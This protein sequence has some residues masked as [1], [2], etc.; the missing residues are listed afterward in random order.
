MARPNSWMPLYWADYWRKTKGLTAAQHGAY[1]N[2]IGAYWAEGGL[3]NDDGFLQRAS[4]MT[5]KE[6]KANKAVIMRYFTVDGDRLINERADQEI[7]SAT[8]VYEKR[9]LAA[10]KTNAHRSGDRHGDRGADRIDKGTADRPTTHNSHSTTVETNIRSMGPD[11]VRALRDDFESFWQAYPRRAGSNPKKTATIAYLKAR[12]IAPHAEIMA[13]L[14]RYTASLTDQ[15]NTPYVAQ[16]VTWLNQERWT[17]EHNP[18]R[19][20]AK[21][22]ATDTAA[23]HLEALAS[24]TGLGH[25]ADRGTSAG[26]PDA[27]EVIDGDFSV[28][29]SPE[30][31]DGWAIPQRDG[32]PDPVRGSVW[33]TNGQRENGSGSLPRNAVSLAERLAGIGH[34]ADSAGM[35]MGQ[36]VADASGN[37]PDNRGRTV[38]TQG[39]INAGADGDETLAI[40]DFLKRTA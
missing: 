2:L 31:L 14:E 20:K 38:P 6:W 37:N 3:P 26:E 29:G 30:T 33:D 36:Q 34:G 40:P 16:A 25:V 15:I 17:D 12:K 18:S 23:E 7:K 27:G 8:D 39:A 19:K 13:G 9:R 10:I 32:A 22:S 28:D 24:L 21:Q 1:L 5:E 11:E 35:V 4:T